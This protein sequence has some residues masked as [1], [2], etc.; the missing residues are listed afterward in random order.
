MTFVKLQSH[1]RDSGVWRPGILDA[2][3]TI[4][5]KHFVAEF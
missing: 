4:S 5:T 2:E 3:Y 1:S